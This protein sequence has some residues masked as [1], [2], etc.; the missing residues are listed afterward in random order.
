MPKAVPDFTKSSNQPSQFEREDDQE[1][2]VS[3]DQ[4]AATMAFKRIKRPIQVRACWLYPPILQS[5]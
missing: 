1:K 4:C 3:E 5:M 2:A